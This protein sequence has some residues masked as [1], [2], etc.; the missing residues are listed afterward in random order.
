MAFEHS[1]ARKPIIALVGASGLLTGSL[2][3]DC[4]PAKE[5][6]RTAERW[7]VLGQ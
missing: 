2:R 1:F 4:F 6:V 5:D 7:S 3:N